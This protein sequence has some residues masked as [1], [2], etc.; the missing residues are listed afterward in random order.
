MTC[1]L[2]VI[3]TATAGCEPPGARSLDL[4][5]ESDREHPDEDGALPAGE[6]DDEGPD[7]DPIDH[8]VAVSSTVGVAATGG[9]TPE[10]TIQLALRE[11]PSRSRAHDRVVLMLHGASV[12]ARPGFDLQGPRYSWARALARSGADVFILDFQ[13]SGRSYRPTPMSHPCNLPVA[14][15]RRVGVDCRVPELPF[16][17]YPFQL[18]SSRSDWEELDRVVDFIRDLRGVE[19]VHLIAWSQ[20]SFRAG[21]YA[22]M[23]EEKVASL[24][25]YAP[26]F[27]TNGRAGAGPGGFDPPASVTLPQPGTPMSVRTRDDLLVNLWAAE[28]SCPGQVE[29]GVPQ[30]VWG[31]ILDEDPLGANWGEGVLRVRTPTLWGWNTAMAARIEVPVLIVQGEHDGGG[32]GVQ[33]LAALYQTLS[34]TRKLRFTVQCA[35]HFL[36]WETR[37]GVLHELSKHWV[38]HGAVV[39]HRTGEFYLG[40]DGKLVPM[41]AAGAP[42][43]P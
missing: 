27:N 31:A 20:G 7:A 25:L 42:A 33:E 18:V 3:A 29:E 5:L 14:D 38:R 19:K 1:V 39:G 16:E 26:I 35:G 11:F 36:V 21:P 23:H 22:V 28:P 10:H 17:P 37:R 8:W 34:S 30:R 2:A 6:E 13:G 4:P 15:Q 43:G 32:G 9:R 41:G 24:F 12:P 40:V